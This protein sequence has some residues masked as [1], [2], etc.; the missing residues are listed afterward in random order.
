MNYKL[1]VLI[2]LTVEYLYSL[3]LIVFRIRSMRIPFR[4][5]LRTFTIRT[6]TGNGGITKVKNPGCR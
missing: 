6:P 5:M 4:R 2:L 1:I 3:L